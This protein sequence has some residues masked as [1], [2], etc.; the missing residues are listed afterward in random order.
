MHPCL[1]SACYTYVYVVQ[2]VL[3][4]SIGL[5]VYRLRINEGITICKQYCMRQSPAL[6]YLPSGQ[7]REPERVRL[8]LC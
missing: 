2:A 3:Y 4:A 1:A 5:R 8:V 6:S 7:A